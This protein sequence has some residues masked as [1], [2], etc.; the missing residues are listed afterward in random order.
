MPECPLK[1]LKILSVRAWFYWLKMVNCKSK[2]GQKIGS[3]VNL[4]NQLNCMVNNAPQ[5]EKLDPTFNQS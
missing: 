4:L 2:K 3:N 1:Y 5:T